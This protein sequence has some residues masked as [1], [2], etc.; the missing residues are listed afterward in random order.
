M[1]SRGYYYVNGNDED[2]V[3]DAK[4]YNSPPIFTFHPAFV[5]LASPVSE[6]RKSS[7]TELTTNI[8]LVI[9]W[10]AQ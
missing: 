3:D 6:I 8:D 10:N 5:R 1:I 9:R 2:D 4:N 7:P